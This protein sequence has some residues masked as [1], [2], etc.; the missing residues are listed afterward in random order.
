MD[1]WL[2]M[3]DIGNLCFHCHEVS[4]FRRLI[5]G[6]RVRCD[7]KPLLTE[8]STRSAENEAEIFFSLLEK[9]PCPVPSLTINFPGRPMGIRYR[10][11]PDITAGTGPT[12]FQD[13]HAHI[14]QADAPE[15][16]RKF[17]SNHPQPSVTLA[18]CWHWP[19]C[20][21]QWL[22]LGAC[23]SA[24]AQVHQMQLTRVGR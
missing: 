12:G 17:G 13:S 6:W 11:S 15:K 23:G 3:H 21:R 10:R 8:E 1:V 14:R 19:D 2:W 22:L 4:G 18:M 9:L 24:A 20:G 16:S 7:G 5:N